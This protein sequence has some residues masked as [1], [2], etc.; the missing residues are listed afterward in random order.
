ME[1]KYRES[2]EEIK[3]RMIRTALDFWNIKNVENLDP[4]IRLLIEALAMQ[5]HLVSEDIADIVK[6]I[7]LT[8]QRRCGKCD[9]ILILPDDVERIVSC[10]LCFML[11][12]FH[13]FAA[14]DAPCG[15]NYGVTV[16]YADRLCRTPL[17][18]RRASHAL[19]YVKRDR[20]LVFFHITPR[21]FCGELLRISLSL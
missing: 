4:F 6:M 13:A 20:M 2:K 3:D 15:I 17:E 10:T 1:G 11:A 7:E 21:A 12:Y 19:R 5:L 8:V 14:V 18:A 16:F 9:R